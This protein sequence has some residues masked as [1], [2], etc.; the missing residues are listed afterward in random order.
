MCH[1]IC[2]TVTLSFI[3][4]LICFYNNIQGDIFKKFK[5]ANGNFK[6]S[7]ITDI[8]G[9]LSLYEATHLRVHGEEILEEALVFTT[10]HLELAISQV[11]CPLKAQISEALERPMWRSLERLSARNYIPIYQATTSHNEAL[12]KLA[13][14]DFNLF[15]ALYKEEL[16]EV[17]RYGEFSSI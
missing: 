16:S 8:P 4:S 5:D 2:Q 3:Q 6:E 13:K 1:Y 11:S 14:L 10:N 17:S 12:L 9:M 7:L 15:Q